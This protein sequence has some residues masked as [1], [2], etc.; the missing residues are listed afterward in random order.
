MQEAI[1]IPEM[2]DSWDATKIITTNPIQYGANLVEEHTSRR[3]VK[4]VH[5][6]VKEFL[7]R[8]ADFPMLLTANDLS[9]LSTNLGTSFKSLGTG[10][11]VN[12][13]LRYLT[14]KDFASQLTVRS[15]AATE[16]PASNVLYSVQQSV[17]TFSKT[18]LLNSI[19][20]LR[21][22]RARQT[23]K[24]IVFTKPT[25]LVS[26]DHEDDTASRFRC[27]RAFRTTWPFLAE[28][29][30][31]GLGLSQIDR[32][33]Q[34]ARGMNSIHRLQ[35]W[36]RQEM[37]YSQYEIAA[38]W[39]AVEHNLPHMLE[40]WRSIIHKSRFETILMSRRPGSDMSPPQ[41]AA[42]LGHT[43][44]L[45]YMKKTNSIMRARH[46]TLD[47]DSL[48][49]NILHYVAMSGIDLGCLP[50]ESGMIPDLVMKKNLYGDTAIDVACQH[51]KF[52]WIEVL[53]STNAK[54][55]TRN[56]DGTMILETMENLI[57][58]ERG[59]LDDNT[60]IFT[61]LIKFACDKG[62]IHQYG[63]IWARLLTESVK[64]DCIAFLGSYMDV[65]DV[66]HHVEI[67]IELMELLCQDLKNAKSS[68][69]E[70]I[71]MLLSRST[72][73]RPMRH[74][75][76][77]GSHALNTA[78]AQV[79]DSPIAAEIVH[80]LV[81]SF[82]KGNPIFA[83]D[84]RLATET[85]LREI[86]MLKPETVILLLSSGLWFLE[87]T[88]ATGDRRNLFQIAV[89]QPTTDL[90]VSLCDW[91]LEGY[92]IGDAAYALEMRN[93]DILTPL[94]LAVSLEK[95]EYTLILVRTSSYC[96]KH[97]R[98][99]N[100]RYDLLLQLM[101]VW[102]LL[103]SRGWREA[104]THIEELEGFVRREA[105]NDAWWDRVRRRVE[106]RMKIL[107]RGSTTVEESLESGFRL[108]GGT[109]LGSSGENSDSLVHYS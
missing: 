23:A 100:N 59:S 52:R 7:E 33:R 71:E 101:L 49:Q 45:S 25:H 29:I 67:S 63:K 47:V 4:F 105:A 42:F 56:C 37:T 13:M 58:N 5:S 97:H 73:D 66:T 70:I 40:L 54:G 99:P 43:E 80:L 108:E 9:Y 65:I 86:G 55:S 10:F 91:V 51:G 81:E 109:S 103:E 36:V 24:S 72:A 62:I 84:T 8:E 102:P 76:V 79:P 53:L 107:K 26:D 16:I 11:C 18:P 35:P 82:H 74:G 69:V 92:S 94:L 30:Y 22:R 78:M 61:Q 6:S 104:S 64:N 83:K 20:A 50:V 68:R 2:N 93:E 17:A 95:E 57:A 12:S 39:Y 31:L 46:D 88:D 77:R 60:R 85:K 106:N 38:I 89:E 19:L 28:E 90:L 96:L 87:R 14:F 32:L 98:S 75:K 41:F 21:P 44:V 15:E 1:G 27:L 34:L 3:L 48:G